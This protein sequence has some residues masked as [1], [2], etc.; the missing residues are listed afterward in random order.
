M[1]IFICTNSMHVY[2]YKCVYI[3]TYIHIIPWYL[4]NELSLG[5]KLQ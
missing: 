4:I 1:Y 2:T 3:H 5:A